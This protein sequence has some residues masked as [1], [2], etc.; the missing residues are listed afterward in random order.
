MVEHRRR[1]AAE[2]RATSPRSAC[3]VSSLRPSS[4][5]ADAWCSNKVRR[6][7]A[8][9]RPDRGDPRRLAIELPAEVGED[10]RRNA[11]DGVERGA[12]H[13]EEADLQRERHAVQGAPAFPD[14]DKFLL[15]E[16][17]EVFDFQG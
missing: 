6:R 17:E 7:L 10:V 4:R 5:R 15:V 1:L 9:E 13:L 3:G 2:V 12:G 16:R 14:F 8:I 11:L